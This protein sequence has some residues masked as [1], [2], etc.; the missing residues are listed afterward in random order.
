MLMTPAHGFSWVG[1]PLAAGISN[2]QILSKKAPELVDPSHKTDLVA[3]PVQSVAETR[4]NTPSITITL[5]V[6]PFTSTPTPAASPSAE[7]DD[8][9]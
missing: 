7:P 8:V 9:E 2:C 4:S 1:V 5:L 6:V 3:K